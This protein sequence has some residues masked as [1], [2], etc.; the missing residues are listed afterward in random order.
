MV[1][2]CILQRQNIEVKQNAPELLGQILKNKRKKIRY[3]LKRTI[4]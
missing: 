1:R 4:L 3:L 2:E